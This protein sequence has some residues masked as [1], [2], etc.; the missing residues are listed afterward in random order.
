VV[1]TRGTRENPPEEWDVSTPDVSDATGESRWF[2]LFLTLV[3][4]LL[5]ACQTGMI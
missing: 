5:V 1:V 4:A 2:W 3:G